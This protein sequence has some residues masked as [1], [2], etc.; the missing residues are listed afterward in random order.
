MVHVMDKLLR[1]CFQL[2]VTDLTQPEL[3]KREINC[4][5]KCH[6]KFFEHRDRS[7]FIMGQKQALE[8]FKLEK[9][10]AE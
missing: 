1:E 7:Q 8:Q 3:Q 9:N 2:C 6:S 10:R 5:K 4:I